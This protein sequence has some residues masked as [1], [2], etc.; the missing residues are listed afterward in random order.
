MEVLFQLRNTMKKSTVSGFKFMLD[1]N[2]FIASDRLLYI[3][4]IEYKYT[5][6]SHLILSATFDFSLALVLEKFLLDL[7]YRQVDEPYGLK[8]TKPLHDL[9]RSLKSSRP[10]CIGPCDSTLLPAGNG[11]KPP[12]DWERVVSCLFARWLF[13]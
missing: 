9:E 6:C 1:F 5:A 4:A 13:T 10:F 3:H 2:D 11:V 7:R 8:V 12:G